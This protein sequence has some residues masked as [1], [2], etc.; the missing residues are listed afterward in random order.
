M[1]IYYYPVSH[2]TKSRVALE[3]RLVM[4][5]ELAISVARPNLDNK[6]GI[7]NFNWDCVGVREC[8]DSFEFIGYRSSRVD[9]Y[10]CLM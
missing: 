4:Q 2:G 9:S 6:R 7:L 5:L 8:S 3:L 10:R 1:F